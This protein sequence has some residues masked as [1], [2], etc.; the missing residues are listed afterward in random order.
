MFFSITS[1]SSTRRNSRQSILTSITSIF[2]RLLNYDPACLRDQLKIFHILEKN[3]LD[4][5]S[6]QQM[7]QAALGLRGR[8]HDVTIVSRPAPELE[9]KAAESGV[10]FEPLP[11]RGAF[12]LQSIRGLARLIRSQ[13]PDVIHVHK[14]IAHTVALAASWRQPVP[15]FVVNRGVSFP[16]S[17]WNRAKYRTRSVDRIV[18]VCQEVRRVI[19]ES[20]KV[21]PDKVEV[22]YAG[23]DLQRFDPD[24]FSGMEFRDEAS[25]PA[26][27][28]VIMQAGIR[29]WKGWRELTQAFAELAPQHPAA[30]LLLVGCKPPELQKEV[31]AY[32]ASCGVAGRLTVTPYRPDLPR[33]MAAADCVVDA[34]WAGTG[35]TGTVREAMALGKP[36]IATDAGGNRELVVP[37][38]GW[39][40]APKDRHAL[41]AALREVIDD[42]GRRAAVARAGMERVRGSF[43]L[44]QRIDRLETIYCQIIEAKRRAAR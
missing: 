4:T 2:R 16:L 28:F 26:D 44:E 43:S 33:V 40:V 39:L 42:P 11:L 25:I 36:V 29:E 9:R 41:I 32:A 5:G 15:A 24:R 10:S 31:E 14:G 22:V 7:L 34:S 38:T 37:G 27:A 6:V 19:I 23:T 21:S 3:G 18:T 8:G 30:W 17:R 20:G 35:V 13:R 1:N 12:E